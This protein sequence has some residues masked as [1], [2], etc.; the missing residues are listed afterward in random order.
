MNGLEDHFDA[1]GF[2]LSGTKNGITGVQL[3]LKI[4]GLPF[5]L[6]KQVIHQSRDS[7]MAMLDIMGATRSE[8]WRELSKNAP[9]LH[10]MQ[11]DPRK[12]GALID[13]GGKTIKKSVELIGAKIDI[14]EDNSGKVLVYANGSEALDYTRNEINGITYEIER[15]KV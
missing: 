4:S 14:N 10:T 5:E 12:I 2:K 8:P 3:D 6:A 7:R 11:I 13:P 9:R 15:N 1:M